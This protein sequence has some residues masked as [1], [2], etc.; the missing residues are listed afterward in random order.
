MCWRFATFRWG[1]ATTLGGFGTAPSMIWNIDEVVERL[2]ST[3]RKQTKVDIYPR[4]KNICG[5][6]YPTC[7]A[8]IATPVS[9]NCQ[10]SAA[11]PLE[12]DSVYPSLFRLL[13]IAD[14]QCMIPS[15]LFLLT[16]FLTISWRNEIV[17][18]FQ[19]LH[20]YYVIN[21]A[22]PSPSPKQKKMKQETTKGIRDSGRHINRKIVHLSWSF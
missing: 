9:Q 17:I 1:R 8:Y 3:Q 14:G 7:I 2:E 22:T 15:T 6:Y 5:I 21:Y 10:H 13:N 12:N 20:H 18:L 16:T 11:D 19:L 4:I